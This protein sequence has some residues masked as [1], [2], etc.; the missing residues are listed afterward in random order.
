MRAPIAGVVLAPFFMTVKPKL[1]DAPT[2]KPPLPFG[3]IVMTFP[4]LSQPGVPF[5]VAEIFCGEVTV[6]VAVQLLIVELPAVMVTLPLK[7]SLPSYMA[8]AHR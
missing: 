4:L 6:T 2:T 8:P 5:Q 3:F 7:R 1:V